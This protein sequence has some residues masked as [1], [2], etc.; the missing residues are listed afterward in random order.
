MRLSHQEPSVNQTLISPGS[1]RAARRLTIGLATMLTAYLFVYALTAPIPSILSSIPD[2]TSYYLDIAVNAAAG[3]GWSLDG[4]LASF[5]LLALCEWVV[6][7][8]F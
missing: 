8:V 3:R 6:V 4:L 2:Y 5:G 7:A 1:E